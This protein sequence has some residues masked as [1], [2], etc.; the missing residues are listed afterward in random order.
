MNIIFL[1]MDGV[2]NSRSS[3]NECKKLFQ[4]KEEYNQYLCEGRGVPYY[5]D[6]HLRD[7]LN[8]ILQT[9]PDCKV[10]W[11]S[12]WRIGLRNSK[13]FIEGLYNQCGFLQ[14]SF[15]SYTP[16]NHEQ[17]WVQILEWLNNFE[18]TYH[19]EKCIILDDSD[20]A[21]I[22]ENINES[23]KIKA[24][25]MINKYGLKF[26]QINNEFGLTNKIKNNILNYFNLI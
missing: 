26:F 11:T 2:V 12:S 20:D 14:N 23:L 4:T 5:I 3:F 18:K 15:L 24:D 10:V 1:D 8:E 9:I 7:N 6:P 22:P 16:I 25:K 19:I 21:K 17:R 13:L